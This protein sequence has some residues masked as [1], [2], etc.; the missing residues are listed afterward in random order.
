MDFTAPLCVY[1]SKARHL[2]IRAID[3]MLMLDARGMVHDRFKELM[4]SESS[5][6]WEFPHKNLEM[7]DS[8][9]PEASLD[10]QSGHELLWDPTPTRLEPRGPRD[11][12]KCLRPSISIGNSKAQ[13]VPSR[14]GLIWC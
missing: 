4:N 2:E 11:L 3:K 7:P 12:S 10:L 6:I 8:F 1:Q 9:L 14:A 13:T 5:E